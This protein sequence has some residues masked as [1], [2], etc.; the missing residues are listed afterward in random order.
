VMLLI[1]AI[2]Y[3]VDG[4]IFKTMERRLEYRWGLSP[5]S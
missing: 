3:I 5:A 4:L 2:G 1:V